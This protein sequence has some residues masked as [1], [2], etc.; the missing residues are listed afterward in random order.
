MRELRGFLEGALARRL[1]SA[2]LLYWT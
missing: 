1:P 2:R